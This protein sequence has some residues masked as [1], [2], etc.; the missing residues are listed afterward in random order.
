MFA[1]LV[2][3]FG[4]DLNRKILFVFG[5]KKEVLVGKPPVILSCSDAVYF[6]IALLAVEPD[7]VLTHQ[8][9]TEAPETVA[10]ALRLYYVHLQFYLY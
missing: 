1:G 2:L 9:E 5:G 3:R 7:T 6:G 8:K 4:E 10:A